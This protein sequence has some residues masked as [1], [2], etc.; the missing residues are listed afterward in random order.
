MEVRKF[1]SGKNVVYE[2]TLAQAI[3]DGVLVELFKNRWENLTRGK[4]LV[5]TAAVWN[6]ISPAGL[7]EIWNE[8]IEWR[9]HDM[10][11]LSEEDQLF[12]TKMNG[13]S[14]WVIEDGQA[15]TIL[16]PDDY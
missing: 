3:A 9:T 4:P 11:R 15:F 12:Q 2:Y 8:Y 16:Y 7:K 14:V 6:E 13:N 1:M 5:V 10:A